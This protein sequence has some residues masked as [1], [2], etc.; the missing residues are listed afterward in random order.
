[1]VAEVAAGATG[2]LTAVVAAAAADKVKAP[3]DE[4]LQ[5][6]KSDASQSKS[7]AVSL[8]FTYKVGKDGR[9]KASTIKPGGWA[10]KVR[11]FTLLPR[12]TAPS[13]YS[14]C[15]AVLVQDGGLRVCCDMHGG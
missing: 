2:D 3:R 13:S 7:K 4:D 14:S 11:P 15:T 10:H 12:P 8:G 6:I 1:M 9:W 5:S